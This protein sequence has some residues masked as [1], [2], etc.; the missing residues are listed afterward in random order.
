[1]TDP[2]Y[3]LAMLR[4]HAISH[5]DRRCHLLI[6]RVITYRRLWSRIERASARLQCEWGVAPSDTVAYVGTGHPDAIVLYA[7]LLRIGANFLPTEL[8]AEDLPSR[9]K[10]S[11]IITSAHA[12]V[13]VTDDAISL[14]HPTA[15]P[16]SLL[17]AGW[18]YGDPILANEDPAAASLLLPSPTGVI[19][20][21]SLQALCAALPRT[22]TSLQ[23]TGAIFTPDRLKN[24]ILPALRD[25][26]T[27]R[28]SAV[29]PGG[30]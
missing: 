6:D 26:Q 27:L 2:A 3:L 20:R 14:E 19:R 13:V 12:K 9:A 17:L 28:F 30:L 5:G 1:M 4:S 25:A 23:V 22:A 10:V 21:L 18:C 7:A 8:D 29:E 16:L 11:A 15:K 24:L